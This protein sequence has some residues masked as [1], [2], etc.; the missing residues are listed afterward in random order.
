M[1]SQIDRNGGYSGDA[2]IKLP[3]RVAT[4]AS[5]THY[6]LQTID[7][8]V[9]V[10]GDRVLDKDNSDQK[11]RGIW[12]A[13]SSDWIRATDFDGSRDAVN[14]TLII[15]NEGLLSGSSVYK[16]SSANPII[17]GSSSLIFIFQSPATLAALA[18]ISGSTLI[19]YLPNGSG[20][21]ATTVGS[22]LQQF[23]RTILDFNIPG[24]GV[25]DATAALQLI[26]TSN[27]ALVVPDGYTMLILGL[28]NFSNLTN[29]SLTT[30]GT[31][32][33]KFGKSGILQ[34][35]GGTDCSVSNA[36]MEGALTTDVAY[37]DSGITLTSY[38]VT[39]TYDDGTTTI[40]LDFTSGLVGNLLTQTFSALTGTL[41]RNTVS[42]GITLDPAK[43]YV[44]DTTGIYASGD[45]HNEM[46]IT[47][48]DSVGASLGTWFQNGGGGTLSFTGATTIKIK[49][50]I[51]QYTHTKTGCSAVYDL[52]K[53]KILYL[54]NNAADSTN[55]PQAAAY[56]IFIS[57]TSRFRFTN[58]KCSLGNQYWLTHNA[59]YNTIITDNEITMSWAGFSGTLINYVHVYKNIIDM[60]QKDAAGNYL[61]NKFVRAKAIGGDGHFGSVIRNNTLLGA[62][63]AIE[64]TNNT[65]SRNASAII[66][67]NYI[68]CEHQ[69]ISATSFQGYCNYYIEN[70]TIDTQAAGIEFSSSDA[71][72]SSIKNNTI[73]Q[74][75][76]DIQ[77]SLIGCTGTSLTDLTIKDNTCYGTDGIQV[78]V[79]GNSSNLVIAHNKT[80][81]Y[82]VAIAVR[83]N[84][85]LSII[86]NECKLISGKARFGYVRYLSGTGQICVFG[87]N[88]T[89]TQRTI[90]KDNVLDAV[91]TYSIS[92]NNQSKVTIKNNIIESSY[93]STYSIYDIAPTATAQDY[94]V[95]GNHLVRTQDTNNIVHSA[96]QFTGS[97]STSKDNYIGTAAA[98]IRE[99]NFVLSSLL[100]RGEH[101]DAINWTPGLIAAGTSVT[102]SF[103]L[104]A[105]GAYA[106]Q[107]L[108]VIPPA[109]LGSIIATAT[110]A[111]GSTTIRLSLFNPTAAG[112][113]PTAGVYYVRTLRE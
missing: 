108:G 71:R 90:I 79:S 51:Y 113:T 47:L 3:C 31:G 46:T 56:H 92:T 99:Y 111:Q 11:L 74:G 52:S 66:K 83:S 64:F 49:L 19:G 16:L 101:D 55:Y 43:K 29:F 1:A 22:K 112:I 18:T 62:S 42:S 25:T 35:A 82:G 50:G 91:S 86:G 53:L 59:T 98:G 14:G 37:Q 104:N 65:V 107:A 39:P 27:M 24:N 89:V 78:V 61:N 36:L 58:N 32:K 28:C 106:V 34:F 8:I 45:G 6:G 69:G 68:S 88:T 20:A 4:N 12:V 97:S 94:Q 85:G 57:G 9:I 109:D 33:I 72:K 60:R 30:S 76:Q 54:I 15:V 23:T 5:I 70:N 93:A 2:A 73:I 48:Y 87:Y 81:T 102:T 105:P 103:N 75:Y 100:T 17:I 10:D 40:A 67:E 96:T 38:F 84:Y 110:V 77:S 21:V 26:A 13:S 80:S 7:N 41:T 44:M 63:W 95:I